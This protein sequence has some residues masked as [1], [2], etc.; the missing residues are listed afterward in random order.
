[1]NIIQTQNRKWHKAK[2]TKPLWAKPMASFFNN[3]EI[4]KFLSL[5]TIEGPAEIRIESMLCRGEAGDV[6][7]QSLEKLETKYVEEFHDATGWVKYVPI[8]SNRI[9][10]FEVTADIGDGYIQAQWGTP[11][12]DIL[13]EFDQSLYTTITKPSETF[14]QKAKIGDIIARNPSDTGDLW[15]IDKSIWKN[16]YE[17]V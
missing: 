8:P 6:W 10:F 12:K 7:Q 3:T 5:K 1:M 11:V 15:V 17:K 9:E 13:E 16:T 14:F 2:K 4:L